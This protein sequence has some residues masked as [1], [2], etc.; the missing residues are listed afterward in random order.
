MPIGARIETGEEEDGRCTHDQRL[1]SRVHAVA[2][3][4]TEVNCQQD[5]VS[6]F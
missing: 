3:L 2:E 4:K 6:E 5:A 1:A